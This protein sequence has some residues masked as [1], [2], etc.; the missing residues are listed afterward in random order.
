[1]D[2][3]ILKQHLAEAEACV[4]LGMHHIEQQR[5][6]IAKLESGGCDSAEARGLLA[7]FEELQVEHI[8]HRDRLRNELSVIPD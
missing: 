8:V 3:F 5:D 2:R 6:L 7:L 1:M 4:T